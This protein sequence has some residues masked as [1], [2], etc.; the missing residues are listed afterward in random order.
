MIPRVMMSEEETGLERAGET[1][2]R[3]KCF[4]NIWERRGW[5][6]HQKK[7][8]LASKA[9]LMR[10]QAKVAIHVDEEGVAPQL[11]MAEEGGPFMVI[12]LQPMTGGLCRFT[13]T[14]TAGENDERTVI[15]I[16]EV[17]ETIVTTSRHRG[18]TFD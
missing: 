16:S 14:T 5:T 13:S 8:N 2:G 1:F 9:W 4:W 17:V 7:V 11:P 15:D 3:A 10:L 6:G 12:R 18:E